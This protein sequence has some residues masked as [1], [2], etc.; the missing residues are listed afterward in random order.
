MGATVIDRD[1]RDLLPPKHRKVRGSQL[2]NPR[3][4]EPNL[5]QLNRIVRLLVQERKHLGVLH[6]STRRHPLHIALPISSGRADRICMIDK[7]LA[8]NGD[9][10]KPAMRMHGK[11]GH[12]FAMI[13]AKAVLYGKILPQVATF[14]KFSWGP[15][16]GGPFRI[17]VKMMDAKNKGLEGWPL[18]IQSK[19]FFDHGLKL[20]AGRFVGQG[21]PF[22][23][24]SCKKSMVIILIPDFPLQFICAK[25]V[26]L[27]IKQRAK[28]QNP[29]GDL[30]KSVFSFIVTSI[31]ALS[32]FAASTPDGKYILDV[33][34][35]NI[36]FEASHFGISNVVGRFNRASGEIDFVAGGASSVRLKIDASSVDTNQKTR[37]GHLR[38]A[39]FFNVEV[40]PTI[41]FESTAVTYNENGDPST[42][43]GNMT[44]LGVSKSV[45]F[46]VQVTGAGV[47]QGKTRAGYV[48]KTLIDRN[49]FGMS[50][51][52]N[53]VGPKIPITLNI[54]IIKQ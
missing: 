21:L 11:A 49:D 47:V 50:G 30:V 54:E 35:F 51:F 12:D 52:P 5:K 24:P 16:L 3:Q 37:D 18:K 10:L 4:V 31:L 48:A 23:E 6:P 44:L 45:S 33:D 27:L 42:I 40:F 25:P 41:E 15:E 34:H 13:H 2:A 39:D 19:L 28:A 32:T 17:A 1:S 7:A 26:L 9:G 20:M 14:K 22:C 36:G 38:G 46:E 43:V 53:I 29:E 8:N